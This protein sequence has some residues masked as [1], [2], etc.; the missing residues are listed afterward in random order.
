MRELCFVIAFL[1]VFC[2]SAQAQE[3]LLRKDKY[4]TEVYL[5]L[6]P[7]NI[8]SVDKG[9][10]K[11]S[12][13]FRNNIK[14]PFTQNFDDNFITSVQGSGNT[15]TINI[16]PGSEYSI[17][18]DINGVKVVATKGKTNSDILSSYGVARPLLSTES[19]DMED[20]NMQDALDQ[21]DRFIASK[22]F[23]Q[24]AQILN[25]V[26]AASKNEFYR[27]EA[28]YKLGQAYM[29]MGQYDAIYYSNAYNT[30]DDF[31]R[32]YPDNFRTTEA[33][34]KSAEAKELANQQFEAINT[35]K[36]IYTSAPDLET[37]RNA[38]KKMASIYKAVG[39]MDEAINAYL[40]YLRRFKTDQ[41]MVNGEI[42]QMYY[43]QKEDNLAFEYFSTLNVQD[44]INNPDTTEKRLNSVADVM[45][46]KNRF[47]KAL[48]LYKAIYEKYPDSPET[49]DA[50][51]KSAE[52]MQKSG[53]SAD[54]DALFLKL[55]EMYPDRE[56][57]Q[58]A[59]MDYAKKYINTKPF[60]YWNDFFSD[61][62][63]RPDSFGLHEE[64]R[65]MLIKTLYKENKIGDAVAMINNFLGLYPDSAYHD[66]LDKI[67]EDYMFSQISDTYGRKDYVTVEPM[68]I[69]F[70]QEYPESAYKPRTDI[71]LNE[72]KFGKI[73]GVYKN[74]DY[75]GAISFAE[76]HLQSG[77]PDKYGDKARWENMLDE[78]FY[79]DLNVIF[80]SENY[81]AARARAKEYLDK[82]PKGKNR[83][84]A[85]SILEK[86][87]MKPLESAYK[88]QDYPTVVQ[89]YDASSDWL[90]SWNNKPFTD[91]AKTMT[92][93]SVYRLGSPSKARTLYAEITPNPKDTNYAV[94][95]LVLGDK[96]LNVDV[97]SFDEATF[98]YIIGE[99]EQLDVDMTL[100]LLDKYTKNK[101]LASEM[102]YALAKNIPSDAKRRQIL[103]EI[104][105]NMKR[106]PDA[107]FDGSD[108]VYMDMGLIFFR[109]NDFKNAVIPLKQFTD[110]YRSKDDKRAEALYYLGKSF[111]NMGDIQRGFQYYNDIINNIS[112]S[113][114]A[115][116]AK[117]E[118][119]EDSWRK[120]LNKY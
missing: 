15:F 10:N 73:D 101:K 99:L 80:A 82:F 87:L 110:I 13:S 39:N 45:F 92:A 106:N 75:K 96:N 4:F 37:K 81:T 71:M 6:D 97:N 104:Y 85:A 33:M 17:V 57:G 36:K 7:K 28:L 22:Q 56:S 8:K 43:D 95:G 114:Y 32:L 100:S 19:T 93:L 48:V 89:L 69:K 66:E 51:L 30:F 58:R 67:R 46:K 34:L 38:L 118:M 65:Y 3:L 47:D 52:I 40:M 112:S 94:L 91:K 109:S 64:A 108:N 90:K 119:D 115:G 120:N 111:I 107:R 77:E 20:K 26:L 35:Y 78:A 102:K 105:D 55:K 61:L 42:G 79:K 53:N 27:Q 31:A 23:Q 70:N 49:N 86:A 116:I 62:F 72:I 74:N 76:A 12:V 84:G 60:D 44:L 88:K 29:L 24:G 5:K 50:I 103:T 25:Q 113:I 1:A 54:A 9:V 14:K 98:K 16:K 21:A 83:K 11:V 59:T 63:T 68:I 2:C 41:D 117:G 18:N